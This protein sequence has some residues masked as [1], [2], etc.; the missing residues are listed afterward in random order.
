[1]GKHC[2]LC[3]AILHFGVR[4]GTFSARITF[5]TACFTTINLSL[6]DGNA[7][8]HLSSQN[9]QNLTKSSLEV[10]RFVL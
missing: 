7:I 1:M 2:T 6:T 4:L 10:C 8:F 9:E 5:P 3:A